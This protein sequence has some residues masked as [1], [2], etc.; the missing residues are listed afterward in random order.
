MADGIL[1]AGGPMSRVSVVASADFPA[2]RQEASRVSTG[3]ETYE[4]RSSSMRLG[5][6][7]EIILFVLSWPR[8]RINYAA[9]LNE[10]KPASRNVNAESPDADSGSAPFPGEL[11]LASYFAGER[12]SM[13]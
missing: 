1:K 12:K 8:L 2:S 6:S 4:A 7:A 9:F 11:N 13:L 10:L 3:S 5:K